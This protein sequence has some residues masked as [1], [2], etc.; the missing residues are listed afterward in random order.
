M[1]T[2]LLLCLPIALLFACST[3]PRRAGQPAFKGMELYSV[4]DA[5]GAWRFALLAGTNRVKDPAE[6]ANAAVPV[7]EVKR[8]LALLAVGELVVWL[9]HG[10][11]E[12]PA[13][14]ESDLLAFAAAHEVRLERVAWRR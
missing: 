3:A 6:I 9:H 12:V 1:R 11:Q 14:I 8:R 4:Q 13:P 7:E 5:R 10:D 2:L